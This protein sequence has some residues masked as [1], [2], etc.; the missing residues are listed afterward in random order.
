MFSVLSSLF[1]HIKKELK[2]ILFCCVALTSRHSRLNDVDDLVNFFDW[3]QILRNQ[4][5]W[6]RISCISACLL[7]NRIWVERLFLRE[8]LNFFVSTSDFGIQIIHHS[9]C[10]FSYFE[11]LNEWI[12]LNDAIL[13]A[14][15]DRCSVANDDILSSQSTQHLI[16]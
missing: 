13:K 8:F 12:G 16:R 15:T 7:C 14:M 6:N 5:P 10:R 11:A 2:S 4:I 9:D 3:N 1:L